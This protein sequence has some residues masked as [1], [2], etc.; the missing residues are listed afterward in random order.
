[1][2]IEKLFRSSRTPSFLPVKLQLSCRTRFENVRGANQRERISRCL[3]ARV[4]RLAP[5]TGDVQKT[6]NWET[7][8]G[9][10]AKQ[11]AYFDSSQQNKV[12]RKGQTDVA[13]HL[14]SRIQARFKPQVD[15][16]RLFPPNLSLSLFLLTATKHQLLPNLLLGLACVDEHYSPTA[17]SIAALSGP[18]TISIN[19][20]LPLAHRYHHADRNRP[21]CGGSCLCLSPNSK[22]SA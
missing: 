19:P 7:S 8:S 16:H 3:I 5:G 22:R 21:S 15:K 14:P 1:M 4:A 6:S 2:S 11:P 20:I 10:W 17:Y 12:L 9:S 18:L 13:S